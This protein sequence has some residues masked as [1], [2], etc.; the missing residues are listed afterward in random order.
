MT[1][2]TIEN[3]AEPTERARPAEHLEAAGAV[4]A[5]GA[6]GAA[7]VA[8]SEPADPARPIPYAR[9]AGFDSPQKWHTLPSLN[10][11]VAALY[12]FITFGLF[13]LFHYQS[14]HDRLPKNR[15]DDPSA[16]RAI[17]FMFIPVFN[18]WWMF[19][20]SLRLLERIDEQR[21]LAGLREWPL[22]ALCVSMLVMLLIPYVNVFSL[23]VVHPVFIASLQ[24][25]INE[26]VKA[27]EGRGETYAAEAS[28]IRRSGAVP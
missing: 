27:T 1:A 10:P 3:A 16:A 24:A 8:S 22:K 4:E 20:A 14:L 19:F 13:S 7:P 23:L 2:D 12:H 9:P 17:G 6:G 15:K 21:R 5:P 11:A 18:L 26:L 25:S 28:V